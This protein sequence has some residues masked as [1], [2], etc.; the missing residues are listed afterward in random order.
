MQINKGLFN[1]C[2]HG[3]GG[4]RLFGTKGTRRANMARDDMRQDQGGGGARL[5]VHYYTTNGRGTA[6]TSKRGKEKE[7]EFS[8]G[9]APANSIF[10]FLFLVANTF[11]LL[12]LSLSVVLW[13]FSE[14]D[15]VH[16]FI[17]STI[18]ILSFFLFPPR[19][20]NASSLFFF[21]F[22]LMFSSSFCYIPTA[23]MGDL[24]LVYECVS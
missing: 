1:G 3:C 11:S 17:F 22:P 13:K 24:S 15:F 18:P 7:K 16:F 20:V 14:S 4:G 2:Q 21:F 6:T 12:V 9:E 8:K 19:T 10:S 23:G 5:H